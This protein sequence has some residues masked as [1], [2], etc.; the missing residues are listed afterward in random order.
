M[1][2]LDVQN[3][4]AQEPDLI[5]AP[6]RRNTINWNFG[7]FLLALRNHSLEE[8]AEILKFFQRTTQGI[9]YKNHWFHPNGK[10]E[11]DS[12]TNEIIAKHVRK[13]DRCTVDEIQRRRA[14]NGYAYVYR[15]LVNGTIDEVRKL[16]RSPK[17]YSVDPEVLSETVPDPQDQIIAAELTLERAQIGHLIQSAR[18]KHCDC[19]GVCAALDVTAHFLD[20]PDPIQGKTFRPSIVKAI[21]ETAGV[22]FPQAR[23]YLRQVNELAHH[24]AALGLIRDSLHMLVPRDGLAEALSQESLTRSD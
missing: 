15:V 19:R 6:G 17:E 7:A 20:D 8:Q 11:W 21:A 22:S 12:I 4:N 13:F 18:N 23:V 9:V 24:D 10:E 16:G 14:N 2:G 3:T 5:F 1:N